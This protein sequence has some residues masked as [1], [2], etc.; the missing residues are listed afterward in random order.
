MRFSV[1]HKKEIFSNATFWGHLNI[2]PFRFV[3]DCKN[4]LASLYF[5]SI[6]SAWANIFFDAQ[7]GIPTFHLSHFEVKV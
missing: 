4:M 2:F 5:N 6:S 7:L 3:H 1:Y